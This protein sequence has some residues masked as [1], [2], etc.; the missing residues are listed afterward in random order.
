MYTNFP[1]NLLEMRLTLKKHL[2]LLGSLFAFGSSSGQDNHY[3]WMQY[4]ARN[5]LL[6]NAGLSRFE[7][8]S[9]VIMNPA[10]LS[11]A[12]NSSFNFNTNAFGFNYVNFKNGLGQGFDLVSSNISVLPSMASGV[13]KPKRNERDWVLG[14]ALYHSATDALNF[15]DRAEQKIDLIPE[16]ESPGTENYLSQYQLNYDLDE[17]SIV[18]GLG[19]NISDKVALGFSQTFVYRGYDLTDK[20]TANVVPDLNTGS[21]V[22]LVSTDYDVF[23][24][25]WKIMTYSKIGVQ[26]RAGTWEF[27]ITLTTPSLGIMG[28]GE[29]NADLRLVNVNLDDDPSTPRRDYLANGRYEKL[30]VKF[31]TPWSLA[32]GATRRFNKVRIYGGLNLFTSIG[33]YKIMDPGETAFIQPPS[34]DNVFAT[35]QLLAVWESRRTVVNG[36]IAADWSIKNGYHFLA[37]L[38]SDQ[39]YNSRTGRDEGINLPKKNWDNYHL[40][41][42]GQK[43]FKSS[44]WF[45]GLRWNYGRNGNFPQPFSFEDPSEDNFLQGERETGTLTS[46]GVQL[47]LSY[48]FKFANR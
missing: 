27:G 13:L 8:Q 30:K 42:G 39:Q 4:G 18:A 9:A 2:V 12:T 11:Q 5:S 34:S 22:D 6:Y 40:T 23:L 31:K 19:W 47:L 17:A 20:F 44:E 33:E 32:M 37:S 14:Y 24:K 15:T 48:T 29:M 16:A 28:G 43:E 7:D 21:T 46:T 45:L 38:R 36:S 1:A 25:Y 35:S 41:F 3:A 10:T 26:A